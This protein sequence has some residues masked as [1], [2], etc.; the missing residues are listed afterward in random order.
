MIK[1]II[2]V[3][4]IM[5]IFFAG[6]CYAKECNLV[7]YG[8]SIIS[9]MHEQENYNIIVP[10]NI[11]KLK[12][13]LSIDEV[14]KAFESID[15]KYRQ[16][17]KN[18]IMV[19]FENKNSNDK[20]IV[21]ASYVQSNIIFYRNDTYESPSVFVR[22]VKVGE[23]GQLDVYK[24]GPDIHKLIQELMIHEVF[25]SYDEKNK[26]SES[27]EWKSI[28]DEDKVILNPFG[29]LDYKEEFAE[30]VVKY[31]LEK[32]HLKENMPERYKYIDNIIAAK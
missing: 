20:I 6:T 18:I 28:V 7:Y 1:K 14:K 30:S 32:E 2:L 4:L 17:I 11:D 15:V 31:F 3:I 29:C 19:D 26:I 25:H 16:G 21:L 12:Q 23:Y 24:S 5:Q 22:S 27:E 8:T 9:T 10:K 13:L